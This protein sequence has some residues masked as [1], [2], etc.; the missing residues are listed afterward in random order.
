MNAAVQTKWPP[1]SWRVAPRLARSGGALSVALVLC[2]ALAANIGPAKVPPAEV[3]G[4]V[5]G[6]I[7]GAP[8]GVSQTHETIVWQF[9]LP[10]VALG[11]LVGACLAGAGATFQGLLLNPLADPYLIGV[12]AGAGLGASVAMLLRLDTIAGGFGVPLFAFAFALLTMALVYRLAMVRGK[13]ELESF[14]LAGVVAGSFLWAGVTLVL[15]LA[16]QDMATIFRWLM[17]NLDI[18]DWR[19]P[20]IVAALALISG[21]GVLMRATELNLLGS[22]EESARQMGVEVERAK[23]T[24]IVL[25]S[26]MTSAAVCFS[27]II[28]FVGLVMPHMA[29]R[30]VGPEHRVL[31]P[32]AALIGACFLVLADTAARSLPEEVPVGIVTAVIGAPFFF[33][34]LRRGRRA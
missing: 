17:G 26:L 3:A 14:I 1:S 20:L 32:C 5:W 33:Y 7:T 28:G 30:I 24:I 15:S 12:S 25:G 8:S 10:R 11:I 22:G 19:P 16:G 4:V 9:R 31:L 27:G 29:R 13:L 6:K 34:L 21:L 2:A 18:Q 23:R